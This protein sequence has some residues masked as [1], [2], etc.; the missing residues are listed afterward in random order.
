MTLRKVT[1]PE[2]FD[3]EVYVSLHP[4]LIAANVDGTEHYLMYG[5]F[6]GRKWRKKSGFVTVAL[7][8]NAQFI[9]P[10]DDPYWSIALS[11]GT[12]EP[13]INWVLLRAVERPYAMID[14]GAN[15]GFWSVL[16]SSA[17]YGS[18]AV[19]AIEPSKSNFECLIRN[20]SANGNRFQTLR[21][22]VF[23]QSGKRVTLYGKKPG[24]LSLRKDWHPDDIDKYEDNIETIT[25][26][27]VA[28]LY[29]PSRKY[30]PII[31]LDVEGSEIEGMKGAHRLVDEGALMIYEDHGKEPAHPVSRFAL[32]LD[33]IE[34]WSVGFDQRA[35]RITAIEQVAA[36]KTNPQAGYNFFAY[37]RSSPWSS[38]FE[39]WSPRE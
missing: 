21:L 27:A 5:F 4:D 18:H 36:I 20:A 6:E 30:P 24:G 25:L 33:G 29:L 1:L 28:D 19:V 34:S 23:D 17:L 3:A 15:Y 37:R 8:D 32:S 38:L 7:N 9:Y 31:K 12:Y 35:T 11:G 22:A 26:D 2:D 13:E 16:A 14:A 39:E 10:E